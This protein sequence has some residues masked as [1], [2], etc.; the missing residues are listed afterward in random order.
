M[1]GVAPGATAKRAPAFATSSNSAGVSTV[2]APTSTSGSSA[3]MRRIAS[4]P[5]GVRS[6]ISITGR[7]PA[8][9]ARASGSACSASSM[10]TTGITAARR[11]VSP[12]LTR[13]GR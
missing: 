4:S 8:A 2:P 11:S 9:N 5:A 13:R 7:P 3:A 6:V 12:M 1:V 10:I